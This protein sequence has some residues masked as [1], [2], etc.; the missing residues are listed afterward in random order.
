MRNTVLLLLLVFTVSMIG[1]SNTSYNQPKQVVISMFGAM[2]KDDKAAL[3]YILDLPELMK[4]TNDDY[5]LNS[6][7][8]RMFTSPQQILEDL[9]EDGKTKTRWFSYQRIIN[10]EEITGSTAMVE[11]TFVDKDKSQAY[12]VKFG[13]HIVNEKWKIYSFNTL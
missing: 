7:N 12:M 6:D 1:C 3:A 4:I 2:E 5:A 8:P 10:K 11:V 9:T 13:L